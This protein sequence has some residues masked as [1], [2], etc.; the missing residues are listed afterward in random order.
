M[1]IYGD[2]VVNFKRNL[3]TNSTISQTKKTTENC[4]FIIFRGCF[5]TTD[6]Q[7]PLKSDHLDINDAQCVK[8]NDGPKISYHIISLLA[9]CKYGQKGRFGR[10]KIQ[11][12]SK[13]AKFSGEIEIDMTFIFA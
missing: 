10:S 5:P 3:S 6:M 12:Y 11:L 4:F 1:I 7:T 13:V 2:I 8:K 9:P